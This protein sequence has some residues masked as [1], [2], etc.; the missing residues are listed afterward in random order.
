MTSKL[1]LAFSLF[2]RTF[3]PRQG[4]TCSAHKRESILNV[5][6][7][8]AI[9]SI[10]SIGE[11]GT[12]IATLPSTRAYRVLTNVLSVL[13][14]GSTSDRTQ[15]GNPTACPISLHFGGI[16]RTSIGE[17]RFI[18]SIVPPRD[19]SN[20]A[21]RFIAASSSSGNPSECVLDHVDFD[22]ISPSTIAS[23][24]ANGFSST[25]IRFVDG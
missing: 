4:L 19:A 16:G 15:R 24:I 10:I 3:S 23:N 8:P 21:Q 9:V 6:A 2:G 12:G 25:A 22:A 17:S 7:P 20:T 14:K 13:T 18:L 1:N 11:M 5:T